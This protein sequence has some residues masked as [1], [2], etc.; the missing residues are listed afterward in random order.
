[1][2]EQEE[3]SRGFAILFFENQENEIVH[4]VVYWSVQGMQYFPFGLGLTN[5]QDLYPLRDDCIMYALRYGNPSANR[6]DEWLNAYTLALR[7]NQESF[8]IDQQNP[9]YPAFSDEDFSIE[10]Y[11]YKFH[12]ENSPLAANRKKSAKS[13]II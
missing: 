11:F 9:P 2:T 13:C 4:E 1:M 7:K 12:F 8:L 6:F 3:E 10:P 5:I